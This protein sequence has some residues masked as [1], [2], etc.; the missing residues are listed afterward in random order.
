MR[1]DTLLD[2]R[3]RAILFL[4]LGNG[5]RRAELAGLRIGDFDE[6]AQTVTVTGK[7]ICAKCSLHKDDAK[8]CQNVLVAEVNGKSVEYYLAKNSVT[9]EY[10]H[11]CKGE[12]M[13]IATG[14]VSEKDGKTW[15]TPTKMEQPT[16]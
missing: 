4:L 8:E 6:R 2:R 9:E 15:L 11:V 14:N 1:G 5:L 16:S 7:I 10:G 12:K 13:V 3:D